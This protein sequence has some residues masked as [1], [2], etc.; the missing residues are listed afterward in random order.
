MKYASKWV[1]VVVT[2]VGATWVGAPA[3]Q[4]DAVYTPFVYNKYE[5]SLA[6]IFA[7]TLGG[8]TF[9]KT[10]ENFSNGLFTAERVS[11]SDD[12]FWSGVLTDVRAVAKFSAYSQSFGYV[13]GDSGGSYTKLFDVTGKGYAVSGG[14]SSIDLGDISR[15]GRGGQGKLYT[16][17]PLSNHDHVDHMLTFRITP[18]VTARTSS[19]LRER[20]MFFFEDLSYAGDRDYNDLVVEGY[21]VA[22]VPIPAAVYGGAALLSLLGVRKWRRDSNRASVNRV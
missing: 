22:A 14:V 15:L 8:G 11:D 16:S 6:G 9:T 21:R 3:A 12:Q 4:A 19:P 1:A 13:P 17:D 10:G 2:V 20:F 18:A 7:N 5:A